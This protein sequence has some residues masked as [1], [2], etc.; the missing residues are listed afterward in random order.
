MAA[1]SADA[2]AGSGEGK[3]MAENDKWLD[4]SGAF[5]A[6]VVNKCIAVIFEIRDG[7]FAI[8]AAAVEIAKRLDALDRAQAV[9]GKQLAETNQALAVLARQNDCLEQAARERQALSEEHYNSAIIEPLGKHAFQLADL[10]DDALA[11]SAPGAGDSSHADLLLGLRAQLFDFLLVYGIEPIRVQ[12]GSPFDARL[13]QP[14]KVL[15]TADPMLHLRV[16]ASLRCG[17]R[18]GE[19]VLRYQSVV[20]NRYE[21]G[22]SA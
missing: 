10:L 12:P 8:K 9:L 2:S 14:L 21:A 17:F 5:I 7:V 13:M 18:R 1:G 15:A 4:K 19:R 16:A 3:G 11:G 22:A 20:I 6:T